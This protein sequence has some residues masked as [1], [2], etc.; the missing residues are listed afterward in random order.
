MLKLITGAAI[1]ALLVGSV[2]AQAGSTIAVGGSAGGNAVLTGAATNSHGLGFSTAGA[3]G[4][5]TGQSA[6]IGVATP[7]G[8]LAA[9][10]GQT[11][12]FAGAGGLTGGVLGGGGSFISG[13]GAGGLNVGGGFTNST[14]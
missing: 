14:P 8:G 7:L 3:A 2:P 4:V 6:G 10:I 11:N 13:A 5:S 1:V 9:G 12:N